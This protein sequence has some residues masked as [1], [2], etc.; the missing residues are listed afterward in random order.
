MITQIFL[1][2][3]FISNRRN[4]FVIVAIRGFR[5]SEF[6]LDTPRQLPQILLKAWQ[7]GKQCQLP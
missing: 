7:H 6:I 3:H 1:Y 2:F 5:I 4:R